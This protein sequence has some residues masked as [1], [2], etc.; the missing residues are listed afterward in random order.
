MDEGA[1]LCLRMLLGLIMF[2][3]LVGV[4]AIIWKELGT[5][6]CGLVETVK[7]REPSEDSVDGEEVGSF[8][9][10]SLETFKVR[11]HSEDVVDGEDETN[12]VLAEDEDFRYI[13]GAGL[14]MCILVAIMFGIFLGV[15][16][17]A[18]FGDGVGSFE[19]DLVETVKVREP[20]EE[21]TSYHKIR[22]MS[23]AFNSIQDTEVDL[24]SFDTTTVEDLSY[25]LE[26][27]PQN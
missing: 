14:C 8:E 9:G 11:E 16:A 18:I 17:T 13:E 20:S 4:T 26:V 10:G 23:Y 3:L 25:M 7:D 21:M 15:G 19:G 2:G 27:K 12:C 1:V 6:V 22:D 24:S 5:F